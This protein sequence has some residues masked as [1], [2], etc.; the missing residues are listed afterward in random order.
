MV[1]PGDLEKMVKQLERAGQDWVKAK[2][3]AEQLEEDAKPYLASLENELESKGES[4]ESKL[5]RLAKGSPQFRKYIQQMCFARAESLKQKVRYEG[6]QALF[7]ARRS[8]YALER[9]KLEKGVT[10]LG[11]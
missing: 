5:E 7:E 3:A 9:V 8:E 4:G 6:F 11:G 10:H 2:L 1:N